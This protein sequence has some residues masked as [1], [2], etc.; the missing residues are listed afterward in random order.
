[1]DID[2]EENVRWPAK[3]KYNCKRN[4]GEHEYSIPIIRREPSVEYIYKTNDGYILN[5]D[6]LHPEYK[7]LHTEI[8]FFVETR[9]KHCGKKVLLL[10]SKK[11]K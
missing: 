7:F 5:S 4:K 3:K 10:F 8:T 1:M 6:K 2:K 9:C 11:I